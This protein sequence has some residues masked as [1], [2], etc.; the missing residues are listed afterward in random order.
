VA[1]RPGDIAAAEA[2]VRRAQAQLDLLKVD[3]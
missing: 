2:E 1:A 3:A